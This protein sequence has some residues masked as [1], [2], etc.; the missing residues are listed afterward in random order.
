MTAGGTRAE[1]PPVWCAEL[2]LGG[3]LPAALEAP[4]GTAYATTRVLVRL[5]GFP[6]GY[7]SEQL[8]DGSVEVPALL[9]LVQEKLL[10]EVNAHLT[11]D[12]VDAVESVPLSG[13]AAASPG[14]PAS[15]VPGTSVSVV[16]CTRD[17][18]EPLRTCLTR[19][20]AL[21]HHAMEVLVVD[22][23]PTDGAARAVFH[24]QVG[25]DARFR[26][27]LEPRPGLSCARNR[28]LAEASGEVIA[29]TD[30][31]VSVDP[32]WVRALAR[33][34]AAEDVAC[35][36]GLVCTAAI[37]GPAELYFDARV[38]WADSCR[39]H[40]YRLG[41]DDD[42][43][44]FPY[45]AGIFGTGA[46]FAFRADVLRRLGGF[47]EALGAGTRTAGGEDLDAFV[48]VLQAGYALAYEPAAVVWHHHRSDLKG[49]RR[50]MYA[51]GTGLSAFL[52]KHL[53]DPR[54]RPEVL[55]RIPR[56][57]AKLSAVPRATTHA[58]GEKASVRPHGFLLRELGGL[59]TGPLLY[60]R[61]RRTVPARAPFHDG[62]AALSAPGDGRC[63]CRSLTCACS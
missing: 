44:L 46:N 58:I 4:A 23:A 60:A 63:D 48:R 39:P 34:F 2:D 25:D 40:V 22:N 3:S 51:Y 42:D 52:T 50:Q 27:V 37:D 17:R 35:V 49:L 28:G 1:R 6:L 43:G 31:D 53:V 8:A 55:R 9:R 20:R 7:V 21:D 36:T 16:V 54:T 15:F 38:S 47:D 61:A 57:L 26:Y 14:C 59:V 33:A 5:H 30:D 45:S 12:G 19:L 62:P 41:S 56:G 13:L 11:A 29:Y 10:D 18:G 32:K 24:D